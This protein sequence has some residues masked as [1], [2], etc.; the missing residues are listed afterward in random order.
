MYGTA[1]DVR[2]EART[3]SDDNPRAPHAKQ[4]VILVVTRKSR[5]APA[6]MSYSVNLAARLGSKILVAYINTLPQLWDGGVRFR[7]LSVAVAESRSTFKCMAEEY[8]VTCDTII[9]NGRVT[10]VV[11]RLCQI[12]RRIDFIV[13]NQSPGLSETMIEAPL[14]IFTLSETQTNEKTGS[15]GR[16]QSERGCWQ[17]QSGSGRRDHVLKALLMGVITAVLYG[18][19]GWQNDLIMDYWTRGGVYA[20]LPATTACLFLVVQSTLVE[21]ML[22]AIKLQRHLPHLTPNH[23]KSKT[24]RDSSVHS[25]SSQ[26]RLQ[27]AGKIDYR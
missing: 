4:S 11:N 8:G 20:A 12:V 18:I 21:H 25:G 9:E 17:D 1:V 10:D 26:L 27:S 5:V 6:V 13:I 19:V 23:H 14:P 22:A 24:F 16:M 7:M 3:G 2:E 15:S